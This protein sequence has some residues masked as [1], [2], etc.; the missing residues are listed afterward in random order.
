MHGGRGGGELSPLLIKSV[1][2]NEG[3]KIQTKREMEEE[4]R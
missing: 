2:E 1:N 3:K 4:I